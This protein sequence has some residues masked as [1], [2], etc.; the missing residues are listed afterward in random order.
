[1]T[2]RIDQGH[3]SPM[4]PDLTR[5]EF[6]KTSAFVGGAAAMAGSVPWAVGRANGSAPSDELGQAAAAEYALNHPESTIYSVCL[7]CHTACNLKAKIQDGI[8]V[9]VDG[10]PY[11]PMNLAPHLDE[12]TPIAD[13]AAVD[14]KLCPKGQAAVQVLYDPYR[15][16]KVLKRKPGT[17]RG[18]GK[19]VTIEWDQFIDE[20]VGGGDLFGEGHVDGFEALYKLRDPGVAKEM[21]ADAA[22]VAKGDLTVQRFK[23]RHRANLDVLI[24]PDHPDLGPINNQFV[25]LGGR[26]EHGRKELAKRFTYSGLGSTN[27]Y[28]HT[29]ICEQSHH[30]AYN[31]M[32][33]DLAAGKG[34]HHMKPDFLASE[35]VIFFGTGA[36]EANFG[37]PPMAE[38]V[39]RGLVDGR[40]RIAVVDPRLSKTAA[41]A[42][43]WVPVK[44]GTDAALALGMIRWIIENQHFDARYLTAANRGA[45]KANGEST[46]STASWLVEVGEDGQPGKLG[47]FGI[48]VNREGAHYEHTTLFADYPA[49]RPF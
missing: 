1:M 22:A 12:A 30:I 19:W 13:A 11:S 43:K 40:L 15:L 27:F 39:T 17:G 21:A 37:P 10:N 47:S 44:P 28:L 34:K 24:D 25:F 5:R 2:D 7:N 14:G 36:F 33:V 8:V 6:V 20:V 46:F 49:K 9:K 35:F 29:T 31:E 32:T 45:A 26:V 3:G 18:E 42:W 16:R 4:N 23:V 48:K 38:K 41:K